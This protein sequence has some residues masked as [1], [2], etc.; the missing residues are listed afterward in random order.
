LAKKVKDKYKDAG[1]VKK[2]DAT[3]NL[4]EKHK[5]NKTTLLKEKMSD[6]FVL[7]I[8]LFQFKIHCDLLIIILPVLFP[9]MLH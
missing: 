3:K 9:L 8:A 6:R 5:M 7:I 4:L 2:R 1:N